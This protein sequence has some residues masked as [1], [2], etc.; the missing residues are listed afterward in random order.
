MLSC[1]GSAAKRQLC[2]GKIFA[3]KYINTTANI[4]I[5]YLGDMGSRYPTYI[6]NEHGHPHG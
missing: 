2:A 6:G 1:G 5:Y 3:R 4:D